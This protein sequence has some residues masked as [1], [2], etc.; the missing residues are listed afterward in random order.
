M[1]NVNQPRSLLT[2][3]L[4]LTSTALLAGNTQTVFQPLPNG[5][6]S[7]GLTGWTTEVSPPAAVTNGSVVEDNGAARLSKGGAF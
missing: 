5:D 1:N 4:L 3:T 7:Q 2:A 6:F